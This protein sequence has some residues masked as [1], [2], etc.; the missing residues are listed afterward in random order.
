MLNEQMGQFFCSRGNVPRQ[1]LGCF[2]RGGEYFPYRKTR[3]RRFNRLLDGQRGTVTDPQ[4]A[5]RHP[6][7]S[8]I[9]QVRGTMIEDWWTLGRWAIAVVL[10]GYIGISGLKKKS[11][12]RSGAIAVCVLHLS[13]RAW[14]HQRCIQ[15]P[16][17]TG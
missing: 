3:R 7:R 8:T 5:V 4:R 14:S 10:A 12:D 17:V 2:V 13:L 11:L 15:T 6:V 1:N 9:S 16:K